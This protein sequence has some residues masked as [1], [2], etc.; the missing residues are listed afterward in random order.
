[1]D[2]TEKVCEREFETIHAL[3]LLRKYLD[4]GKPVSGLLSVYPDDA[5]SCRRLNDSYGDG[6]VRLLSRGAP[7][8]LLL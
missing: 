8:I 5:L 6:A 4:S 1:M 7:K 2:G 3:S